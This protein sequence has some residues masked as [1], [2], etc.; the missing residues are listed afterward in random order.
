MDSRC[1]IALL[2]LLMIGLQLQVRLGAGGAPIQRGGWQLEQRQ[3]SL[4]RLGIDLASS[5]VSVL[6]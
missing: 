1:L 2:A 4:R 5:A 6:R 3:A